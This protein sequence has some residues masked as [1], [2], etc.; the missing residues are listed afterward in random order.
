MARKQNPVILVPG[1]QASN[2]RDAYPVTPETVWDLSLRSMLLKATERVTPHPYTAGGSFARYY[3]LKGP[4]R[5]QPDH[6]FGM[7]YG[8]MVG[9]LRHQ[10]ADKPQLE[11]V[12][13]FPFA[14]DWRQPLEF[15]LQDLDAMVREVIERT[16]LLPHYVDDDWASDPKVDLVG[17]S[18]GGLVAAGF[19]DEEQNKNRK[20][21][22]K[23][24]TLA[25]P[26]RGSYE[27][28]MALTTGRAILNLEAIKAS[29]VITAR[30]TPALYY[31]LP[32]HQPVLYNGTPYA[33]D[34]VGYEFFEPTYWQS[35]VISGIR[36]SIQAA[37]FKGKVDPEE[38]FRNFLGQ[39]KRFRMRLENMTLHVPGL[40][41]VGLGEDTRYNLKVDSNSTGWVQLDLRSVERKNH[42]GFPDQRDSEE[43]GDG[44]VPFRGALS[45]L[46]KREELVCVDSGDFRYFE[47]MGDRAFAAAAGLHGA[48]P[49]MDLV[50]RLVVRFLRSTPDTYGST[51]GKPAPGVADGQWKPPFDTIP[52]IK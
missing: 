22:G 28:V 7:V 52:E 32:S 29:E 21:I 13:V 51:S 12:P 39:A 27:S 46:F 20:R 41:I 43:T 16:L 48:L 38:V 35:N 11:P 24:V 42:W 44:T 3:E 15:T 17:H 18:M 10:L 6:I 45:N 49:T 50:H 25:A 19:L 37:G 23:L 8:E 31:L 5:V 40:C 14:Y 34:A 36:E 33:G 47:E 4:S 26:F 2:L 30:L 1:I 9:S